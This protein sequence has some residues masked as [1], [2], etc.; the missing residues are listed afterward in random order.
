MIVNMCTVY[1]GCYEKSMIA[2]CKTL[3]QFKTNFVGKFG[4]TSP[5][6]KELPNLIGNYI[7]ALMPSGNMLILSLGE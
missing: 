6:L 3:C 1:V 5:G 4:V 2:L 7:P